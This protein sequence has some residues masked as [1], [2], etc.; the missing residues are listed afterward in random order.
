MVQILRNWQKDSDLAGIRDQAALAKLPAEEQQGFKRL[1]ADV[2]KLLNH[3][4]NPSTKD[5]NH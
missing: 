5:S 1:W 4:K 3:A 2:A